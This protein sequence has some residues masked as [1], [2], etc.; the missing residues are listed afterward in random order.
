ME[1]EIKN[2]KNT[3]YLLL[4]LVILA[5]VLAGAQTLQINALEKNIETGTIGASKDVSLTL[6]NSQRTTPAAQP[7]PTM[8]GGC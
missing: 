1:Q 5:V 7:A 8:V 6:E 4:G 2:Q 3:N